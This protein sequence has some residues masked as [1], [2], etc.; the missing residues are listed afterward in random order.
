MPPEARVVAI[1]QA[2]MGSHRLPGK[3]LADIAGQPMLARVVARVKGARTLDEVVVATSQASEDDPIAELC[4]EQGVPCSRGSAEDVLDRFHQAAVEHRADIIVRITGDC[5]LIDSE[6][7]DETVGAFQ[8][9][10]PPVDFACNRLSWDRTY[11]I[12]TD[13]EVCSRKALDEAWREADQPHQREHVMPYLYEHPERFRMIQVR[14][15]DPSLG[16]LRWTVD[17]ADDLAFVRQVYARLGGREDFSW[18]EVLDLVRREP[19]LARINA[20]VVHKGH[21]DVG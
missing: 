18:R 4:R 5:P 14:S 17:E 7:I 16:G 20:A 1:V 11:P 6:L 13:T 10:T 8:S 9:A 3:V 21:R 2:R 15:S 12:G 19:E